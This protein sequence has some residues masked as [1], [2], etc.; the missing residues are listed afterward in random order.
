MSN[1]SKTFKLY[2]EYYD[3]IYNKKNYR[4]EV[5]DI[6]KLLKKFKFNKKNIL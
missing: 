2:G 1:Y 3:L 5:D 4:R 6:T